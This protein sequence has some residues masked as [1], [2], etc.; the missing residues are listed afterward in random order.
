MAVDRMG[1][2]PFCLLREKWFIIAPLFEIDSFTAYGHPGVISRRQEHESPLNALLCKI[3]GELTKRE[4]KQKSAIR[5][6]HAFFMVDGNLAATGGLF[7][8]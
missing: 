7:V 4:P 5:R 8:N 1:G 2:V 3:I 6:V